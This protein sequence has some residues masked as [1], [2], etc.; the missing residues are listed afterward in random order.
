MK[1]CKYLKQEVEIILTP[2][3]LKHKR[4]CNMLLLGTSLRTEKYLLTYFRI[5]TSISTRVLTQQ[6][7]VCCF[8]TLQVPGYKALNEL[9]RPPTKLN[10]FIST[11]LNY[12]ALINH[13]KI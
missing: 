13:K 7:P 2:G 5:Y 4:F 1:F 11:E 6:I 3:L 12:S 9:F 8:L 10:N